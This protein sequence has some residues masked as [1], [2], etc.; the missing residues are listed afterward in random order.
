MQD[1]KSIN[2]WKYKK[3]F[4]EILRIRLI[5]EEIALRYP[6]GK[7]RCPTHLSIGQ[8]AIPVAV[9]DFLQTTD[10]VVSSHR[11]H[12]HYLA[13]GGSLPALIAELYGRETG[14]TQGCG[15]S[16]NLSDLAAGFVASKAII[17]NTI[18]VGVGLAFAQQLKKSNSITCIFLGDAAIEEGAFYESLNFAVLR[19]LPVIFICENN[20]YSVNTHLNL[21]QP[22][23][24]P[25][26][27][28][29]KGIGAQAAQYDGNDLLSYYDAMQNI[30]S[31]LRENGGPWFLEF[32]TY[33]HKAHCGHEDDLDE[34]YR[35]KVELDY[36]LAKDPLLAYKKQLLEQHIISEQEI[37]KDQLRI[38][39]EIRK[40]FVF[41]EQS[42]FPPK[43]S[44][45][46][47]QYA[48]SNLDWLE[49]VLT[50]EK[51]G[52]LN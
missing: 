51:E 25:I 45:F 44:R 4:Y 9:C 26:F 35:P 20:F 17:A 38:S 24:R 23:D 16:M 47:N 34:K 50:A 13:K 39:E 5:E 29:A 33:R 3:L 43:E 22:K 6:E 32:L 52:V 15:G 11:S 7:M 18:P 40:A 14:C 8:E 48:E 27:E 28:L 37:Q 42:P 2:N 10:L 30:F 1:S 36:W 41:A 46:I 12:A 49:K 31:E 19:K 21:R